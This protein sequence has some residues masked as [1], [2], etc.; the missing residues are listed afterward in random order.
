MCS[1]V[2]DQALILR[3]DEGRRLPP[4][5]QL[6]NLPISNPSFLKETNITLHKQRFAFQSRTHV[7]ADGLSLAVQLLGTSHAGMKQK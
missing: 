7:S 5:R 6:M 1:L 3:L 2:I 4:K